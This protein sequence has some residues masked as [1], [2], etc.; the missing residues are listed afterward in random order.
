MGAS[1]RS[2]TTMGARIAAK[3]D[4]NYGDYPTRDDNCDAAFS[5]ASHPWRLPLPHIRAWRPLPHPRRRSHLRRTHG[6]HTLDTHPHPELS[7]GHP[8]PPGHGLRTRAL[9]LAC[10]DP[11]PRDCACRVGVLP[12]PRTWRTAV[13]EECTCE[14]R[15]L[16]YVAVDCAGRAGC[17]SKVASGKGVPGED[18]QVAS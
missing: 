2:T 4:L 9:A 6:H 15:Q 7:T 13:R 17:L 18:T 5:H 3:N 10:A 1:F 16:A 12:R 8:L 11:D 14:L